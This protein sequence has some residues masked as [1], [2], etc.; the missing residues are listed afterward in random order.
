MPHKIQQSS[1]ATTSARAFS[2]HFSPPQPL[3][4]IIKKCQS[5]VLSTT[6]RTSQ[7]TSS[8]HTYM[9]RYWHCG[10][11]PTRTFVIPHTTHWSSTTVKLQLNKQ[12]E[13]KLIHRQEINLCVAKILYLYLS[14]SLYPGT[15]YSL[16]LRG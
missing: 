10:T 5:L 2:N 3:F 15:R 7:P 12:V 6:R 4:N 14:L 13:I 1:F 8:T 9:Y 16:S 11:V